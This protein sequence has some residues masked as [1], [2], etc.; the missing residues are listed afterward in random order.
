MTA[1]AVASSFWS[2]E[3]VMS[4]L[5]PPC[6]V[7][8][9]CVTTS[10]GEYA[11][12]APPAKASAAATAPRSSAMRFMSPP[13]RASSVSTLRDTALSASVQQLGRLYPLLVVVAVEEDLA[14]RE[15]ARLRR[16]DPDAR[17]QERV[18]PQVEAL[19]GAQEA[20]TREVPAG[21]LQRLHH[22]PGHGHAVPV[23]DVRDAAGRVVLAHDRPVELRRRVL[24]PDRVV[25]VLH[26][27]DRERAAGELGRDGAADRHDPRLDRDRA[28]VDLRLPAELVGTRERLDRE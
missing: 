21:F 25:R 20:R 13:C 28:H 16:P 26:V 11:A 17:E 4:V 1:R 15:V 10:F 14:D 6:G 3:T 7:S 23:V 2:T 24:R 5:P 8:G 12:S 22:R 18:V 9:V 19:G 27:R